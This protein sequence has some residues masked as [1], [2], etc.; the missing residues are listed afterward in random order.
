MR[1]H[2]LLGFATEVGWD[3]GRMAESGEEPWTH[4]VRLCESARR[5]RPNGSGP[6]LHHGGDLVF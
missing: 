2:A 5:V 6:P 3:E 1:L 4:H